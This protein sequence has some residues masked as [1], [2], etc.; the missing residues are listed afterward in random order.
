[1]NIAHPY[2]A[3]GELNMLLAADSSETS[4]CKCLTPAQEEA[5]MRSSEEGVIR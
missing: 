1:M 5:G 2:S 3:V 4:L